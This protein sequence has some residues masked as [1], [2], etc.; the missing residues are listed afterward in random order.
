MTSKI[1][2]CLEEKEKRFLSRLILI[3]RRKKNR[4]SEYDH[5]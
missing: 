4:R 1:K 3:Q 2:I 5:E